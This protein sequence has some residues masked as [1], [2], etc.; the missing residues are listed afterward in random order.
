MKQSDAT[1]M[2]RYLLGQL[3]AAERDACE[4]EWFTDKAQYV[5]L[6]EA[7]NALIDDYVRGHLHGAERMLF[8]QHFLTIPAR[9]ERVLTAQAFVQMID[10][11][12]TPTESR[13]QR[14]RAGWH[15][16]QLIPALALVVLLLMGGLWLYQRQRGWQQQLAQTAATAAEQ[17]RRAQALEPALAA[18]RAANARLTEDL[19][20]RN[21]AA[22]PPA[23]AAAPKTLLFALT[24]G[25]LRSDSGDALPALKLAKDVA[26]VQLQVKLPAHQYKRLAATLRTADGRA[27]QQWTVKTTDT[28]LLLMLPAKQLKAGDYVLVVDGLN[29]QR[30][31]EEFRRVPFQVNH[32]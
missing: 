3:P 20:R 32:P 13:W 15:A 11:P 21:E 16:P 27:V 26:R 23:P 24:A 10:A 8:E 25:V 14:W 2:T 12:A 17:Q 18:E 9:R 4:Q 7:E 1:T 29:A 6:C 31:A 22:V 28:R 19:A 30:E 5:L